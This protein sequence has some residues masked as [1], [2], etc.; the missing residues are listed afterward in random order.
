MKNFRL[1]A[2]RAKNDRSNGPQPALFTVVAAQKDLGKQQQEMAAAASR[3]V[4]LGLPALP[5]FRIKESL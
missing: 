1:F 3:S 2:N 4:A 5:E